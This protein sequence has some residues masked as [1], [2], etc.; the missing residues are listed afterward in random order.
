MYLVRREGIENDA[1]ETEDS[2]ENLEVLSAYQ[3]KVQA[4]SGYLIN[5]SQVTEP[6]QEDDDPM[7][8]RKRPARLSKIRAVMALKQ[9]VYDENDDDD[10]DEKTNR[11]TKRKSI[12]SGGDTGAPANKRSGSSRRKTKVQILMEAQAQERLE[13]K[14]RREQLDG[15][16]LICSLN[17][18]QGKD[19]C[20][21]C[22]SNT[23]RELLQ[24]GDLEGFKANFEDRENI[25]SY[26]EEDKPNGLDLISYAIILEKFD[27]AEYA[28][29]TSSMVN[30]E[31]KQRPVVP[32]KN[33]VYDDHTGHN[34]GIGAYSNRAFR[35][36]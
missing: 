26:T 4:D 24:R 17:H 36:V 34:R 35:Y 12:K 3:Q 27:F 33:K 16:A 11:N 31:V 5:Q 6:I 21:M 18:V 13:R 28:E 32:R 2:I 25:P 14:K 1:W 10:D 9:P 23:Y 8:P 19:C 30:E 29:K 7:I 22:A 20:L 15:E